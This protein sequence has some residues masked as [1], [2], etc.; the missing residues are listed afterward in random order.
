LPELVGGEPDRHCHSKKDK[1]CRDNR[2]PGYSSGADPTRHGRMLQETVFS[3]PVLK[4]QPSAQ[5]TS[6]L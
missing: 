5:P 6:D 2:Q 4:A 3:Y 1:H